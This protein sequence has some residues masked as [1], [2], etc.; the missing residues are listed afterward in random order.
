VSALRPHYAVAAPQ[1]ILE[2]GL[3]LAQW[4]PLALA[5][6]ASVLRAKGSQGVAPG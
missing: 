3:N 6:L 1:A 2:F 4:I 5:R